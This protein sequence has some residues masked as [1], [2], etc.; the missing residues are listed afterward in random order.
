MIGNVG[1]PGLEKVCQ[2]QFVQCSSRFEDGPGGRLRPLLPTKRNAYPS[3]PKANTSRGRRT[4]MKNEVI[5]ITRQDQL[6]LAI[7][8][9]RLLQIYREI[10]VQCIS[11]PK[12]IPRYFGPTGIGLGSNWRVRRVWRLWGRRLQLELPTQHFL[13]LQVS[14]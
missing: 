11:Y 8:I 4:A 9:S 2:I 10:P 7:E 14:A 13:R 12:R 1:G 6:G 5:R 3:N